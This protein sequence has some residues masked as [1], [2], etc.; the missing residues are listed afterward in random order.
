MWHPDMPESYKNQIV[1]GDARELARAIPDNSIDLVLTDPPFGI[2]FNYKSTFKDDPTVYFDLM[3][4]VV[5]ESNRVIRPGGLCFVFVAQLRLRE[6][7]QLFPDDSRIFAACK[8]FSQTLPIAVQIAYEPVI[9]WAKGKGNC[10]NI[11][12]DWHIGNTANT[13]SFEHKDPG[14]HACPRP[15]GTIRYIVEKWCPINGIVLDWFM[16]SGTTA[17]AAKLL[18][19]Q[20]TGSEIDPD[21]AERARIRVLQTQMP[22]PGLNVPTQTEML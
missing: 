22:L 21:T 1:T 11:G 7:W 4:W 5:R 19:R 20:W 12:R 17:V 10:V 14:W 15:L 2:G 16:G 9:Y 13:H 18:E 3:R 8:N 6:A